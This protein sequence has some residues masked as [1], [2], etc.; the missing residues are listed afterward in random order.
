[1]TSTAPTLQQE[2]EEK[3]TAMLLSNLKKAKTANWLDMA[4]ACR[5]LL[6]H[7]NW[8]IEK[9]S[10][11]FH[12]S[13]YLLRQIDKINELNDDVKELVKNGQLGLEESYLLW[14][15]GE[16]I[17]TRVAKEAKGLTAHEFRQVVHLMKRQNMRVREA[18]KV[19]EGLRTEKVHIMMLPL[20][21]ETFELLVKLSKARHD[22]NI[23]DTAVHILEDYL[24]AHR[25]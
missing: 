20:N 11:F 25:R 7:P 19:T 12:V 14:R 22:S 18:R 17:Q 4:T 21:S 2:E 24:N 10:E 16:E 5:F 6:R 13:K 9:M 23:H 3:A 15:L 1:M 8:G